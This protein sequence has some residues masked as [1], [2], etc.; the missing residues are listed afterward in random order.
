MCKA[1]WVCSK[2]A[3]PSVVSACVAAA[4]VDWNGGG[5]GV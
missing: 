1:N 3:S 5:N 4:V 2:F